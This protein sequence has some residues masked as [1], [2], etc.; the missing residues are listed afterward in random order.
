MK[1]FL[2]MFICLMLILPAAFAEKN[3]ADAKIGDVI[4]FGH[5]EQDGKTRNGKEEIEWL[6]LDKQD[7]RLLVISRYGLDAKPY[8]RMNANITWE[9]CTLRTWLNDD[10]LKEAF[11]GD[12]QARILTVTVSD[13]K[14]PDH[15]TDPGKATQDQIFLL[16][17]SEAEQ[18]FASDSARQCK[19]TAYAKKQG[20]DRKDG[21]YYWWW[22]RS[23]GHRQLLAACVLGGGNIRT[24]GDA[25]S[26]E[27]LAIR[28]A[29]WIQLKP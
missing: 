1:R 21:S 3:P 11:T 17:I 5:Y 23:P 29:M 28:P 25:V 9:N 19:I 12:E 26:R 14:N 13:E 2:L 24:I 15:G 18:Y 27:G 10:F 4:T 22:L 16:S 8:N 6:V 7:D 20:A